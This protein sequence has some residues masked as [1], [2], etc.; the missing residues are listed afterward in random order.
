VPVAPS[1]RILKGAALRERIRTERGWAAR[2][3]LAQKPHPKQLEI[4][5]AVMDG[6]HARTEV[7]GCVGS[8]K[9]LGLAIVALVWLMSYKPSRVFSLAPS[10]RQ[11][12]ANLWGYIKQLWH[13]AKANGTPI[14]ADKD[15]LK[16]PKIN[17][18]DGWYYEGF[19]TD[20]PHNVHGLH[21]MND[22]VIIDDAHGI[23]QALADEIENITAGGNTKIVLA[24]NKMVLHG[25][26]YE[27]NHRETAFWNHVGISYADL[28]EA[29]SLGF[30]LPGA[31]GAD[32]EGRW[33]AKYGRESNFYRTKVLNLYPKQEHDT[34]IPLEWIELAYDRKVPDK[35]D[36]VIGGDVGAQGDDASALAPMRGFMVGPIEE[37]HEPDLMVTT[38]RF[39]DAIRK[40]EAHEDGAAQRSHAY[41]FVDGV[42]IGAGVVNR[43]AEQT[44]KAT[45]HRAGCRGCEERVKVEAVIGSEAPIG[46]VEHGGV[47]K[48]AVD[49][50]KNLRSQVWWNLRESLN[51]ANAN[52]VGL[53]R[54]DDL[55]AQL[56]CIKWRIGSDGL[57]E[58]EPKLSP[59]GMV[60]AGGT[61]AWGIKQR[62][63]FSP[64]KGDAVAYVVWGGARAVHGEYT[65]ASGGAVPRIEG[66]SD[67][68]TAALPDAGAFVDGIPADGGL[69]GVN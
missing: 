15:M 5:R 33:A 7:S 56:S 28:V 62:L 12:D 2:R 31:L 32:A 36:L 9:T 19:T 13:A 1:P 68:Q 57:I 58:V 10:F 52:L 25:P 50:F 38:G 21:G 41:A 55:T 64:N 3:I 45:G 24:Y 16:V 53:T 59:S 43:L 66:S 48:D 40:E 27:C 46:R 65:P 14:G 4:E 20:E 22:L 44:H 67:Y 63:G 47:M 54:D 34:L 26:T 42:G 17:L 8:G 11:V 61:A 18:G 49:V 51:P 35:G 69:D 37:W 30:D 6:A 39:M 29:R 23:S 60:R